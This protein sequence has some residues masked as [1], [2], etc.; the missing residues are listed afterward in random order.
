MSRF[1]F[2]PGQDA[3]ERTDVGVT[4]AGVRRGGFVDFTLGEPDPEFSEPLSGLHVVYL[5]SKP[6]ADAEPEAVLAAATLKGSA[7]AEDL[8]RGGEITV[9]V[10]GVP[11]GRHWAQSILE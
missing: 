10:V 4:L 3:A 1:V 9:V 11:P 7:S 2:G 8:A 5:E 6:A